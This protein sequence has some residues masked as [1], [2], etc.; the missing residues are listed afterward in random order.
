A[1]ESIEPRE[2]RVLPRGNW[3][4]ETGEVVEPGGLTGLPPLRV[5]GR[6]PNRLDLAD[7]L[8]SPE[9]P[10]TA[11]VFV[12]RLWRNY[13]GKGLSEVLD[14]LGSQGNLPTHPDLLDWLAVEFRESGWDVKHM[15]RLMV[16]SSAYRQSSRPTPEMLK[17]D[18]LNKL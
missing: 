14:D 3:L 16:T 7:W 1:T 17:V 2:V 4:D 10:L 9:N 11:R 18:P 13:F 5:E 12:N 6:R 8:V 15:V